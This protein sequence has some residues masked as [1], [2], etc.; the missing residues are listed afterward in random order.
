MIELRGLENKG[1]RLE[2]CSE[3]KDTVNLLGYANYFAPERL[4]KVFCKEIDLQIPYK[5]DDEQGIMIVMVRKCRKIIKGLY[6]H[7]L[8]IFALVR[9]FQNGTLYCRYCKK[10]VPEQCQ[11]V[12]LLNFLSK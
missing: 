9:Q 6:G 11:I 4:E 12:A 3:I 7:L 10:V 2:S 8:A 1:V 5:I